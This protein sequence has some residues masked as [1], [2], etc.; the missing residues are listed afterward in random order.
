[1]KHAKKPETV[2]RK[3]D[4]IV[5]RSD[6]HTA[7]LSYGDRVGVKTVTVELR[8]NV[9][10]RIEVMYNDGAVCSVQ[11]NDSHWARHIMRQN[12]DKW[13]A[14]FILRDASQRPKR[15]R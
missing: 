12:A 6:N 11:F 13:G 14:R 5:A 2:V 4:R 8:H 1:M 10:A 7:M 3:D 15:R 9:A